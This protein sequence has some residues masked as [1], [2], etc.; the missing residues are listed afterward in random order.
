VIEQTDVERAIIFVAGTEDEE[1]RFHPENLLL[2]E[3]I[4]PAQ[5][6]SGALARW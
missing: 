2:C 1:Y 4:P 5:L 6:R 3:P